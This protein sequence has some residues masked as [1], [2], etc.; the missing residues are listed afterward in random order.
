MKKLLCS[1]VSYV[2]NHSKKF[3]V[4][5]IFSWLKIEC[6]FLTNISLSV[7]LAIWK[8]QFYVRRTATKV[9]QVYQQK[10][11]WLGSRNVLISRAPSLGCTCKNA[12]KS[13]KK[14]YAIFL[15]I[16]RGSRSYSCAV[17]MSLKRK[18]SIFEGL[19]N[20]R[21]IV[22][23]F[24]REKGSPSTLFES[25]KF[26]IKEKHHSN[27]IWLWSANQRRPFFA[28][29]GDFLKG[30]NIELENSNGRISEVTQNATR[31]EVQIKDLLSE[32]ECINNELKPLPEECFVT[33]RLVYNKD[34]PEKYNPEGFVT[35]EKGDMSVSNQGE[36][37]SWVQFAHFGP[38]LS[39][40]LANS[41]HKMM[42]FSYL[43]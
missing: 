43:L 12:S 10:C 36:F 29:E 26:T 28:V 6:A 3:L 23:G 14:K 20:I 32:F 35:D 11:L 38:F 13:S 16:F 40:F 37:K 4:N 17:G 19:D 21:A 31:L 34:T 25:Y 39:R 18:K 15:S 24:Y 33:M 8:F 22:F 41:Y 42:E 5:K 1:A 30:C 9:A 2:S 7:M 27:Q